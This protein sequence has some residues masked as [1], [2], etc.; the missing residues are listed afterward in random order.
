MHN[1]GVGIQAILRMPM[2][3]RSFATFIARL[4]IIPAMLALVI[5]SSLSA[6]SASPQANAAKRAITEKDLFNFV[7][8]ADPQ[9]SPDGSRS[10]FT[11]VVTDEKRTAYESSIWMVNTSGNEATVRLTNGKH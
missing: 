2:K 1:R 6:Q 10:V 5:V 8:I 3:F 9:I 4:I 7:W 11:R